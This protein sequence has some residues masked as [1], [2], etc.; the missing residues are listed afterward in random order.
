M[1]PEVGN[2]SSRVAM[3]ASA[4]SVAEGKKTVNKLYPDNLPSWSCMNIDDSV[5]LL[6]GTK[7]DDSI[8]VLEGVF[9]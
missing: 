7:L 1:F 4:L 2:M 9:P 8:K 5:N 6:F 3:P